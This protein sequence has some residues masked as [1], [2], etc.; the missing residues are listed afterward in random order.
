MN[1]YLKVFAMLRGDLAGPLQALRDESIGTA[2][3]V[4]GFNNVGLLHGWLALLVSITQGGLDL[5]R[6]A[7]GANALVLA[8]CTE[9]EFSFWP[10]L[11]EAMDAETLDAANAWLVDHN[12]AAL[13]AATRRTVIQALFTMFE[14]NCDIQSIYIA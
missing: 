5:L 3:Q 11:D 2:S 8:I 7:A 9:S 10:E 4:N 13:A 14:P 1:D 12:E 6:Q